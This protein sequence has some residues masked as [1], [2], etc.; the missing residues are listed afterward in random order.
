MAKGMLLF[1]RGVR[2]VVVV[3]A[4]APVALR[5]PVLP[6]GIVGEVIQVRLCRRRA[7]G[8]YQSLIPERVSLNTVAHARTVIQQQLVLVFSPARRRYLARVGYL[9]GQVRPRIG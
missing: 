9:N 7:F 2:V 5:A 8:R 4:V 6:Q 3:V 1:R